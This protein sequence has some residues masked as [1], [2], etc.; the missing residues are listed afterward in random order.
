MLHAKEPRKR[1]KVSPRS[2]PAFVCT[3]FVGVFG[4]LM[5]IC[6]LRLAQLLATLPTGTAAG[7]YLLRVTSSNGN[8]SEFEAGY[9]RRPTFFGGRSWRYPI[10]TFLVTAFPNSSGCNG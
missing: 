5:K 9:N 8:F 7:T 3:G 2:F 10:R 4:T 6:N 1:A